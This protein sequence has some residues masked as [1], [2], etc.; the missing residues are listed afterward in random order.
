MAQVR[1]SGPGCWTAWYP[2]LAWHAVKCVPAPKWPTSAQASP[3]RTHPAGQGR[4][5]PRPPSRYPSPC[6]ASADPSGTSASMA[7]N[8]ALRSADLMGDAMA[9]VSR[10]QP[11]PAVTGR[12]SQPGAHQRVD[13][14][15]TGVRVLPPHPLAVEA[16]PEV[17]HV[18]RRT[19]AL[20]LRRPPV[21][22]ALS[23]GPVITEAPE[24]LAKH[25]CSIHVFMLPEAGPRL[26][27]IRR[28]LSV[29]S[30]RSTGRPVAACAGLTGNRIGPETSHLRRS[31][32]AGRL[33]CPLK[34]RPCGP[35]TARSPAPGR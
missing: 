19:Q 25:A 4:K 34:A 29:R 27:A 6:Q 24:N 20:S 23:R 3:G 33:T 10:G 9:S 31:T 13:L 14:S 22:S 8:I 17:M 7:G 5:V 11:Q 12:G 1:Q 35:S 32:S 16:N 15:S 26:R 2:S 28:V 18:Q 21:R 30:T